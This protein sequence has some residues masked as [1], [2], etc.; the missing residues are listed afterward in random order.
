MNFAAHCLQLFVMKSL[1][2]SAIPKALAAPQCRLT[3]HH[4]EKL[5][6]TEELQ[7]RQQSMSQPKEEGL[8]HN[9]TALFYVCQSLFD[10]NASS[11]L[12]YNKGS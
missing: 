4:S 7:K 3:L 11:R 12:I 1:W 5:E 9:G 8:K 6:A 2:L 10:L